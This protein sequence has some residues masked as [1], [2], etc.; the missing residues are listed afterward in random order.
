MRILPFKARPSDETHRVATP[1]ELFFDL[2]C[3]VAIAATTAAYHHQISYGYAW[4]FFFPYIFIITSV[5]WVWAN[6]TWFATSFDNDDSLY[7]FLVFIMIGGFAVFAG[8]VE[9]IFSTSDARFG[10]ISWII[11]RL[12]LISLWFRAAKENPQYRR[13]ALT[14]GIG[15][16]IIQ[17]LWFLAF[18]VL[19]LPAS[20]FYIVGA[21]IM[22][23]EFLVPII[24]LKAGHPPLHK[25]HMI[26][27]H[28][29]LNIIVLGEIIL[30]STFFFKELHGM[31][32]DYALLLGGIVTVAIACL[33]W[34][35]YFIEEDHEAAIQTQNQF[36]W[37]GYGHVI[38]Y[39][40]AALFG[41]ASA[42]QFDVLTDHSKA[43][44]LALALLTNGAIAAYIFG[45]WLIRDNHLGNRKIFLISLVAPIIFIVL[46]VLKTPYWLTGLTLLG[47]V[48]L[49]RW[50]SHK[51]SHN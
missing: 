17:A 33:L 36:T 23:G 20:T 21:A 7:R 3:V 2:V 25:H 5:W 24:A 44:P 11:M 39:V 27:R 1:L 29:L 26:E 31:S 9:Y 50:L 41:A 46:G 35:Y 19:N 22:L 13:A 8:G 51:A 48:M 16:A 45:L 37:W 15:L 30:A 12:A 43:A 49:R 14:Y 42:A 47:V 28:G 32:I 6:F 38:I 10:V 34:V 18:Y 4:E 40:S